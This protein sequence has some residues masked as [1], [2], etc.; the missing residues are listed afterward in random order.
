MQKSADPRMRQGLHGLFD[1]SLPDGWGLLLMDR[2]LRERG[3]SMPV[4]PLDRLAF[5]GDT[6]MGALAYEPADSP[7]TNDSLFDLRELAD[8]SMRVFEGEAGQVLPMLARAGGSPGGAR[9]KVLVG[10][11]AGKQMIS[12]EA[13]LPQ[14][15]EHWII[16]FA[17]RSDASTAGR[18]EY[19]YYLM[20]LDAGLPMMPSALFEVDSI[21]YFGTRRFDRDGNRRIHMHTVGN[22]VDADFRLPSLSYVDLCRL[23]LNL[24]KNHSDLLML[25]RMMV[26]NVAAHNRDDHAKNFAYL[27]DAS[28]DWRLAPPYDLTYSSGPGGEH[29]TDVSGKGKGITQA[30]MLK[31]ARDTGITPSKAKEIIDQVQ[32]IV[33]HSAPHFEKAGVAPI[34]LQ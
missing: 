3:H 25:F 29:T 18:L 33:A 22:L 13:D 26:F 34:K 16:K 11:N 17:T 1:D 31:V 19:A 12:G 20:A 7:D 4:Q 10:I 27:M 6:G 9:P 5:I 14:D 2:V 21:A 24:T 28:G 32:D 23:T 8:A 15:F 30:D